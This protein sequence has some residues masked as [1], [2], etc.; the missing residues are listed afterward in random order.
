MPLLCR[1]QRDEHGKHSDDTYIYIE[2][3]R[4][5]EEEGW[6]YGEGGEEVTETK[7][8]RGKLQKEGNENGRATFFFFFASLFDPVSSFRLITAV[9]GRE[10]NGHNWPLKTGCLPL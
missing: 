4:K 7:T 2:G 8:G 9:P 3:E 1:L 6:K 5:K 10:I